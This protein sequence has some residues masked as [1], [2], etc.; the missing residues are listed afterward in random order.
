MKKN[1]SNFNYYTIL[2][3]QGHE[4]SKNIPHAG[5]FSE[6]ND[7]SLYICWTE[8]ETYTTTKEN[9]NNF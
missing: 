6:E 2:Q 4:C 9:K 1:R 3:C 7:V 5:L 8:I